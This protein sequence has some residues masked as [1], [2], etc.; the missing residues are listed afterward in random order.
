MV[1]KKIFHTTMSKFYLGKKLYAFVHELVVFGIKQA[2]ACLFGGLMLGAILL[3]LFGEWNMVSRYDAL[4]FCAITI[5]ALLL[6]FRLETLA[7]AR[8]IFLFHIVG[9]LMELFKTSP[10]IGS[11][12]YPEV[13][14]FRIMGVPLFSGFL[15]SCVG[16]YI[17][18]SRRVMKSQY[19]NY[20]AQ[21]KAIALSVLIY[22]N[23]FTHH[24][25]WDIR[26]VL[27]VATFWIFRKT[28]ASFTV[29]EKE[30]SMPL[31]L[32]FFLITFF[33][34]IAENIGTF[35]GVWLYPEQEWQWQMVSFSKFG[36]WFLLMII[37]F[38]MVEALH[39]SR[40]K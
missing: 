4:F 1:Q 28:K 14:F 8:V 29:T 38:V 24:F 30:R 37:S 6:L 22:A 15:Y 11:W 16:S 5:Q 40:K 13:S 35:A 23:F 39:S 27:F 19:D 21:W 18:R 25:I 2:W 20:P 7:E 9:T 12:A 31:L 36:S 26:I 10:D 33:I 32:G 3:S 17:A 34:W